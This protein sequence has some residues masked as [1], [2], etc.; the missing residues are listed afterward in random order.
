M[1]AHTIQ[2]YAD[3]QRSELLAVWEQSVLATHHF[4]STEDFRIIKNLLQ[5]LDL[6]E[7]T[8]F[9]L[10]SGDRVTGFMALY[11]RKIEMLFLHP[12]FIGQGYGKKL[13]RFA[14]DNFDANLIDV[15]EQN[16]A[17]LAFYEKMG[18]EVFA[19]SEKDDLGKSYPLLRMRRK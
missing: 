1:N 10:M 7:F 15:N 9:C 14:F 8:I 5:D 3:R 17:A 2:K 12:E 6:N 16:T 4:L 13:I 19:R 18:F 11:E